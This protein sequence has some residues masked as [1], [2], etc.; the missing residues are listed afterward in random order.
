[1]LFLKNYTVLSKVTLFLH[2]LADTIKIVKTYTH[3][4]LLGLARQVSSIGLFS[5]FQKR[6]NW[7]WQIICF[8][9]IS[10][11]K[12]SIRENFDKRHDPQCHDFPSQSV[13]A[14]LSRKLKSAQN[15]DPQRLPYINRFLLILNQ[16]LIFRFIEFGNGYPHTHNFLSSHPFIFY[17]RSTHW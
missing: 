2:R 13:T 9:V 11:P 8:Q 1:M 4:F 10:T 16:K 5:A 17:L 12:H 14:R 15:R 7:V 6:T 3:A